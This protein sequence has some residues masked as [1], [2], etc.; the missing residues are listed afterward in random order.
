VLSLVIWALIMAG[1]LL[2][3]ISLYQ[4][5]TGAYDND[6]GGL[7]VVNDATMNTGQLD[8][9]GNEISRGRMAGPV[10]EKNRYAQ[11]MIVL[12]PLALS[13]LWAERAW[14]LRLLGVLS[15]IPILG[16]ALLTF[17][18][19]AGVALVI[20]LL[21]MLAMRLVKWWQLLLIVAFGY[22]FISLAVPDYLYRMTTTAD[23]AELAT[24]NADE[25]GGSVQGRATENLGTLYTFLDHPLLGVGPGQT[26]RYAMAYGNEVGF[27]KLTSE[28]RAHN[29]YLEELADT[30][31][32]GFGLFAA[33][34][35]ITLSQLLRL[36]QAWRA[37]PAKAYTLAG[38]FL[39]LVA[40]L[41]SAFFLHLSYVRYYWLILALASAAYEIW[42][43][44]PPKHLPPAQQLAHPPN[45]TPRIKQPLHWKQPVNS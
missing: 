29:M 24:G 4:E 32:L 34:L 2:G 9:F 20:T 8:G 18:R 19:G 12:L 16:G 5:V 23:V 35:W 38:L 27:R 45:P 22:L 26:S 7:S 10:G 37:D 11:I 39:G 36:R 43:I 1:V 21:V 33:M 15:C 41:G 25:A 40:Y 17:S 42:K 30:G 6:F 13:R 3:G 28:R 31:I 14:G 44:E